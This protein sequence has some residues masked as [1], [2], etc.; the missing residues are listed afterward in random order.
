MARFPFRRYSFQG[1]LVKRQIPALAVIVSGV[2]QWILF[3][4]SEIQTIHIVCIYFSYLKFEKNNLF[5]F[6]KFST[7]NE[8][9]VDKYRVCPRDDLQPNSQTYYTSIVTCRL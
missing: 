2:V 9:T 6:S 1:V 4:V 5:A 7:E 8:K 3:N